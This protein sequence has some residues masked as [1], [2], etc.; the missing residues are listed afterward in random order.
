L[1]D[2]HPDFLEASLELLALGEEHHPQ[3]L[4]DSLLDSLLVAL[5]HPASILPEDRAQLTLC[6][7]RV[8]DGLRKGGENSST[9]SALR[10]IWVYIPKT[11]SL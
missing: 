4:V 11:S 5:L 9:V 1:A 3:D 7:K 10:G 8:H 2:H 6:R